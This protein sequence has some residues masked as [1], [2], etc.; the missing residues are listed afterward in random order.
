MNPLGQQLSILIR[1][2]L[3]CLGTSSLQ[4][5]SVSLVLQSLRGNQ[6]LD[7]GSL[8]IGLCTFLLG[9]NFTA[10]DKFAVEKLC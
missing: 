4:G 5:D 2:I 10:N 3:G 9:D 8:G 7:L 6:S 1:S